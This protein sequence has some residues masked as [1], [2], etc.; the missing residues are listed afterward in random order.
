MSRR[1]TA[2]RHQYIRR[3]T[4]PAGGAGAGQ[5]S[6]C[7]GHHERQGSHPPQVGRPVSVHTNMLP[8]SPPWPTFIS[9]QHHVSTLPCPGGVGCPMDS[10]TCASP[11][12]PPTHPPTHVQVLV[13]CRL[14]H[15]SA[16]R[17]RGAAVPSSARPSAQHCNVSAHTYVGC[18]QQ[19]AEATW[20]WRN[21]PR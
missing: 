8:G 19:L 20:Q 11:T 3:L 15:A 14:P 12:H 18:P 21:A 2:G 6:D 5:A 9:F 10:D 7:L 4:E 16:A 17:W 13:L 1:C